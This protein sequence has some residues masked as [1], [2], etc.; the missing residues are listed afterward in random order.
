MLLACCSAF[1]A[2]SDGR[3]GC[4]WPRCCISGIR[5]RPWLSWMPI[6]IGS[7][8]HVIKM[9]SSLKTLTPSFVNNECVPS[10]A[11]LP[12]LI[13]DVGK[14]WNVSACLDHAD[15][16]RKGSWVMHLALF[17][18]PFATPTCCVEGLRIGRPLCVNHVC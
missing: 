1:H 6:R 7:P 4:Q 16:F 17:V 5:Y 9:A 13:R 18:S 2:C 15:S 11:G 12:M 14:S 8:L 10:S 3:R